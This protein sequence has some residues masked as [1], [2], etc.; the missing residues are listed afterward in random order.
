MFNSAVSLLT[1]AHIIWASPYHSD[2]I[3]ESSENNPT[4][5]NIFEKF[6][7]NSIEGNWLNESGDTMISFH[8]DNT[9]RTITIYDYIE[10]VVIKDGI[11]S[12]RDGELMLKPYR[13]K[14]NG[15][16]LFYQRFKPMISNDA[17][18]LYLNMMRSGFEITLE[19]KKMN[20]TAVKEFEN[21][22]EKCG[23]WRWCDKTP[24]DR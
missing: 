14:C 20:K 21:S 18:V 9:Y 17:E 12:I 8:K 15:E 1:I 3:L 16:E 13:R 6:S 4:E 11:Y 7:S 5:I 23:T 19:F 10:E 22:M 2:I 24:L